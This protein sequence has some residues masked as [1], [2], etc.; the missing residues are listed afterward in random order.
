MTEIKQLERN[1]AITWPWG[2]GSVCP[3]SHQAIC[4]RWEKNPE[5]LVNLDQGKGLLSA[6]VGFSP[7]IETHF[8]HALIWLLVCVHWFLSLHPVL[9]FCNDILER[10]WVAWEE[11]SPWGRQNSA[12]RS[13]I[14]ALALE[15]SKTLD[16]FASMLWTEVLKMRLT[17]VPFQDFKQSH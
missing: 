10:W 1:R 12:D 4:S 17:T 9:C 6:W 7:R 3:P 13:W 15:S 2:A 11:M 14:P 5:C 16:K 8:S